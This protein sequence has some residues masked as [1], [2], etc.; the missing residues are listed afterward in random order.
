MTTSNLLFAGILISGI[1]LSMAIDWRPM[2]DGLIIRNQ[3]LV[4]AII[5]IIITILIYFYKRTLNK[6]AQNPITEA[7]VLIAYGKKKEAIEL[8]EEYLLKEDRDDVREK[9]MEIRSK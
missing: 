8:L 5:T 7:E 9:L 4:W 6:E 1:L 2:H 3:Y